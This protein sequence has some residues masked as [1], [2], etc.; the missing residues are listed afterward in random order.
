MS[1]LN[2]T[3]ISDESAAG[4]NLILAADGTTTIPGGINR[5]QIVGYQQGV[6]TPTLQSTSATNGGV[7]SYTDVGWCRIGNLVTVKYIF[8]TSAGTQGNANVNDVWMF[9]GLPYT[10]IGG[11]GPCLSQAWMTGMW[12][13]GNRWFMQCFPSENNDILKWG[14]SFEGNTATTRAN[15]SWRC[16]AQYFTEDTDWKPQNGATVAP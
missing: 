2:C 6:W 15:K 10:P 14:G 16:M 11:A 8:L 5:P 7:A 3:N 12:D 9:S 1:N 13:T 4:N